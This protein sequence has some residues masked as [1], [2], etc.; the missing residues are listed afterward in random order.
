MTNDPIYLQIK[1]YLMFLITQNRSD[2]QYL[3]PSEKQLSLRFNCSRLPATRALE[4]LK[5]EGVIYRVQGRGSFIK[6]SNDT[7]SPYYEKKSV[8]LLIPNI[9]STY[10]R[11]IV[12]GIQN[13]LMQKNINLF[14]VFTQ[15]MRETEIM[16]VDSAIG[17]LFDGLI[18]FPV[19]RDIPGK[20]L[21]SLITKK[22]PLLFIARKPSGVTASSV[23]CDDFSLLTSTVRYLAERGHKN[24]GFIT[25]PGEFSESYAERIRAYQ[26]CTL[27]LNSPSYLCEVELVSTLAT[28]ANRQKTGNRITGFFDKNADKL[29][30][31][32]FPS[33]T[34]EYV[35]SNVERLR[36]TPDQLFLISIDRPESPLTSRIPDLLFV[37]QQPEQMGR[38]AAD[39]ISKQILYSLQPEEI[40]IEPQ[41]VP[42]N[43]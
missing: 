27:E 15:D 26:T 24:I 20:T 42:F 29:S 8:C 28:E 38:L 10:S 6:T 5:E 43:D 35:L 33:Q 9:D 34:F 32:I 4:E 30:A 14:C 17:K 21:F 18:V 31:L 40:F 37:D 41:I 22:Y 36:L 7:N 23:C 12:N 25:E 2:K 3:L 39:L 13:H 19:L 16:M 1:K 11:N